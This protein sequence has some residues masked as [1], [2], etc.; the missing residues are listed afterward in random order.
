MKVLKSHKVITVDC[1]DTLVMW[2][3][4]KY[5]E[6]ERIELDCYGP[7]MLALNQK[8]IN[9]VRKLSKLGYEI[10]VWSQTGYDWAQ[11]VGKA[12]G[13]D[14]IVSLYM[15]KPRYYVDDLESK[16]WIGDRLWRDPVTGNSTFEDHE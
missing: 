15:T 4:S 10:I 14:D 1:D 2:D 9:L 6:L 5:P 13:L 11:A 12:T 16:I 3:L 8:N 7:V